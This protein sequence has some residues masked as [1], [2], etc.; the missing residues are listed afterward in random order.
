[1]WRGNRAFWLTSME[2]SAF[3]VDGRATQ[4]LVPSLLDDAVPDG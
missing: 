3:F 1:M 2:N 4:N